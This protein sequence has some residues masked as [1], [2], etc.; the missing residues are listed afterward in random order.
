M[1]N[2][3]GIFSCH[4]ISYSCFLV[5]ISLCFILMST[6]I[7]DTAFGIVSGIY[8]QFPIQ[9]LELKW[10][11][12]RDITTRRSKWV[13]LSSE[14]IFSIQHVSFPVFISLSICFRLLSST[15]AFIQLPLIQKCTVLAVVQFQTVLFMALLLVQFDKYKS[16][17]CMM[18]YF[19]P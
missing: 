11:V 17:T 19:F 18:L 7:G 6:S 13:G 4:V 14:V 12:L 9:A 16:N 5:K 1:Y 8:Y 10:N 3:H 15:E 2:S